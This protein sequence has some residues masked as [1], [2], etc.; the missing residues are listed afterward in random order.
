MLDAAGNNLNLAG[1][2]D[3][4][5]TLL[6]DAGY[7]S[8]DNITNTADD[9]PDLLIAT[10]A[11]RKLRRAAAEGAEPD[12][13]TMTRCSPVAQK[14]TERLSSPEGR[15]LYK[16]RGHIIQTVFAD[17]KHNRG[18]RRFC[19]PGRQACNAEWTLIC[20]A[21]NLRTWAAARN[22]AAAAVL[23]GYLASAR[24]VCCASTARFA[25]LI[26]PSHP[27]SASRLS[28]PRKYATARI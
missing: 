27:T 23:T 20:A 11:E 8:D 3:R 14:M 25:A 12:Q 15:D 13:D 2:K 16:Q 18:R 9:G 21:R 19:Q 5:G 22:R 6:A 4:I 26:A 24:A 1:V 10:A 28:P 7:Y 17:T